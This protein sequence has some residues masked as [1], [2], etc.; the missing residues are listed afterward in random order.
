MNVTEIEEDEIDLVDLFKDLGK[1]LW[2][3]ILCLLIGGGAAFAYCEYVA[4]PMY[5]STATMYIRSQQT[6]AHAM[7]SLADLQTSSQLAHDYQEMISSRTFIYELKR[8]LDLDYSYKHI[9]ENMLSVENPDDTRILK[10]TITSDDQDEAK[11]MANR[12]ARIAKDKISD[13]VITDEP[14]I[15][16]KAI[17][18]AKPVSPEK[19]KLTLIGALAGALLAVM[20]ITIVHVVNDKIKGSDGVQKY[21]DL[22]VL[23]SV[24]KDDNASNDKRKE[25]ARLQSKGRK[26]R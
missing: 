18:P 8:K 20:I 21:L 26:S 17:R 10:I 5:E 16:D 9:V 12:L 6:Q 14:V 3:I 2:I 25:I 22:A 1:K 13:I 23:A 19:T 11:A 4:T 24:P 15:Y 7:T